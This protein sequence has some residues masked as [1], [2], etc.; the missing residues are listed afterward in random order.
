[1]HRL[2]PLLLAFAWLLAATPAAAGDPC[3]Q[4]RTQSAAAD[5][6]TRIAAIAC[7]ENHAWYRTFIDADGRSGGQAVYEA[8]ND[9]LAD[10]TPAWRK[11]A[12]YWSGSGMPG[13][14][15]GSSTRTPPIAGTARWP[16]RH[17]SKTTPFH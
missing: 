16:R 7:Q 17:S 12:A 2:L 13:R 1:M 10:G 5:V 6:A 8:E 3:P 9:V 14:P 4:L 11:V 15:M